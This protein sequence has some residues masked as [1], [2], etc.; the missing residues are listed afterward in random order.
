M[1]YLLADGSHAMKGRTGANHPSWKGGVT[2]ERQAFYASPEWREACCAVWHRA[3]AQCER[4]TADHR[5]HSQ[6]G[7]FHVHH[8]VSF[9]VRELRASVS[10][11]ALLCRDCHLFVHSKKNVTGEFL[12]GGRKQWR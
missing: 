3:D 5:D 6:R 7:S 11:L 9:A 10:N 8:I 12:G 4:C 2:P 1:P